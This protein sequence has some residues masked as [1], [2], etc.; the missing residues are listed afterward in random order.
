MRNLVSSLA[1]TAVLAPVLLC[2]ACGD[3]AAPG[4][5]AGVGGQGGEADTGRTLVDA[6]PRDAAPRPAAGRRALHRR[7]APP[8]RRCGGR[9][10]A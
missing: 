5:G 10:R 9:R 3:T 8:R 6:R 4:A 1:R 7:A 2:L